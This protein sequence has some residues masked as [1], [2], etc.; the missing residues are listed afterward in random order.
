[1]ASIDTI[2]YSDKND[3]VITNVSFIIVTKTFL[4]EIINSF[5]LQKDIAVRGCCSGGVV[6]VA[7]V[8][9]AF[10]SLLQPANVPSLFLGCFIS[11]IG[12]F[13]LVG[14]KEYTKNP[15]FYLAIML[16][17]GGISIGVLGQVNSSTI[18]LIVL[19]L[20]ITLFGIFM[21][22]S[23]R[24]YVLVIRAKIGTSE[25]LEDYDGLYG[26]LP[27]IEEGAAALQRAIEEQV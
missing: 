12:T 15:Y 24:Q 4:L 10:F 17:F 1:M 13:L 6:V 16:V 3:V 5:Y 22:I 27:Y 2:F 9:L 11:L 18:L 7:G 8:G 25:E 19:G 26:P 21:L 23:S 14:K 20:L